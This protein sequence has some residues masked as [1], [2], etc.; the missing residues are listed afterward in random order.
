MVQKYIKEKLNEEIDEHTE[1]Q[2]HLLHTLKNTVPANITS[3]ANAIET[4]KQMQEQAREDL[5][6]K[7]NNIDDQ[8]RDIHPDII[9]YREQTGI[10]TDNIKSVELFI[11]EINNKFIQL[12]PEVFG[13]KVT[14]LVNTSNQMLVLAEH[15]VD[16][17]NEL[18]KIAKAE[19]E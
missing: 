12:D 14:D 9:E 8:I 13:E 17:L 3:V 10:S 18:K 6:E 4:T 16:T 2:L 1:K 5:I 7:I 11:Q 19:E 15:L